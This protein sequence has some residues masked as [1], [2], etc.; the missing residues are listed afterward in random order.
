[1]MKL[2]QT[3]VEWAIRS[4]DKHGDTDLFPRPIE[5]GALTGSLT[6]AV[7]KISDLDISNH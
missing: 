6:S 3:S 7:G 5:L 1:M 4:L 2:D